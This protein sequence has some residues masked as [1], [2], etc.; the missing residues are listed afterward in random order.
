MAAAAKLQDLEDLLD[1]LTTAAE[2]GERKV[3]VADVLD[4]FGRRSFG[5]LLLLAGLLGMTPVSAMPG[6]PS[7]IALVVLLLAGQIV[8]GRRSPWLPRAILKLRIKCEHLHRTVEVA[9]RPARFVDNF[10]RPRLTFLTGPGVDRL[11][12]AVCVLI[13]LTV[14]PLEFLPL[15]AIVPSAAIA[16][17][18]LGLV[19]RDGAVL[20]AAFALSGGA[21][22]L[23]ARQLLS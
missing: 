13:A 8:L 10:V 7:T 3:S 9:K 18:G 22:F 2:K 1:R 14:P 15:V 4:E 6:A 16:A 5:P 20:L 12:A 21:V 11:V 17:F 23:L 19:A